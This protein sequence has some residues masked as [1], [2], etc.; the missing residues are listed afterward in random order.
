VRLIGFVR[1]GGA[2]VA[3]L[4]VAGEVVLAAAGE[5]AGGF[6]VLSVDEEAGVRLRAPDGR[7]FALAAES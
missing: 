7:E 6:T 1:R 5:A 2:L 4:S 3:A